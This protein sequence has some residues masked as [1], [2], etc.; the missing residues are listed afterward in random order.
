MIAILSV[1]LL[2]ATA[3]TS[4][5]PASLKRA[6]QELNQAAFEEAQQRDDTATRA[7]SA[8]AIKTSGGKCLSVDPLSGDFR[9]N[10]TPVQVTNC[11]GSD[12]QK[13][14]IITRGK[15]NNRQGAML[16]VSTLTQACLNFDP[17]R[18][19][20]NQ[21]NLFSCGGRA[22]GRGE[23]T[24]SQL[25]TFAGGAGPTSLKLASGAEI[26]LA[27]KGNVLDQATCAGQSNAAQSFSFG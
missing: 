23:Q 2:A 10:L 25:F 16:V 21:V 14:D 13:W 27:V 17:R 20:G 11:N 7:F 5:S 22:D 6:V 1:L 24:D 12:G 18:P 4:A 9:A 15:H 26:C 19:A 8:T 3:L